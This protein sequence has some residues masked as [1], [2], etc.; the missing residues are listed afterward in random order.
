MTMAEAVGVGLGFLAIVAPEFW[1]KMPKALSYTLAGI[2]LSWLTYSL[3]LGIESYTHMKLQYGPLGAIIFGAIL[4][5]IGLFW[6]FSRQDTGEPPTS[7][8]HHPPAEASAPKAEPAFRFEKNAFVETKLIKWGNGDNSGLFETRYYL[9]VGN[10]MNTGRQIK[11]AKARIFFMGQEP[12]LARVKESGELSTDIRHGEWAFFEI[13]KM[14][15][16]DA[17]P[18]GGAVFYG[19]EE[20]KRYQHIKPEHPKHLEILLPSGQSAYGIF[21]SH[22]TPPGV[23]PMSM[24]IAA[25]DM[26]SLQLKV[27][28]DLFKKAPI[29][30]EEIK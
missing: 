10:A 23:W 22:D 29:T 19:D 25:D 7:H 5:A 16:N 2:G 9:L 21:Q 12:R 18:T 8:G 1:P 28:L 11:N 14:V 20:K 13:G 4:I 6:H 3:V 17:F 24:V 15:T 27:S 26:V 30:F